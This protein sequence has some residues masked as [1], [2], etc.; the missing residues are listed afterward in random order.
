MPFTVEQAN[1]MLPLVRRI[2]EDIV[3]TF[4]RWQEQQARYELV[5]AQSRA[6]RPS[7]ATAALE[8]EVLALA[9]EIDGFDAE[10]AALG[11]ECKS[12]QIGLVDFPSEIDGRSVYLCWRLGEPSVRYW[13]ELGARYADRQLLP[14]AVA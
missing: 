1:R 13:H 10:L 14:G 6:D 9:R 4:A 7:A 8:R 11:I 3:R 5:A 12:Y 2:V